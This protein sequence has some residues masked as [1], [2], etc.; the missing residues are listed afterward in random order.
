MAPGPHWG[1][2]GFG[3]QNS[4]KVDGESCPV[5]GKVLVPG[6]EILETWAEDI[7][8]DL[9]AGGD[10]S[11]GWAPSRSLAVS[12][13]LEAEGRELPDMLFYKAADDGEFDLQWWPESAEMTPPAALKTLERAH[14]QFMRICAEKKDAEIGL[15][16]SRCEQLNLGRLFRLHMMQERE[17]FSKVRNALRQQEDLPVKAEGAEACADV[18]HL[19]PDMLMPLTREFQPLLRIGGLHERLRRELL[20]RDRSHLDLDDLL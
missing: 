12:W 20:K 1:S 17:Q 6:K 7:I 15:M 4:Q 3:P 2:S 9:T 5:F 10:A 13:G 14:A 8:E 19:P 16:R 18:P 11:G